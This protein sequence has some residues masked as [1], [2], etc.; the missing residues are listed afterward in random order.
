MRNV[1]SILPEWLEKPLKHFVKTVYYFGNARFCPICENSSRRLLQAGS[2]PRQDAQCP[3]CGSLERHRFLWLYL[4]QRTSFFDGQEKRVLHIAP[5]PCFESR[6]RKRLGKNYL[7]ADLLNP[8]AMVKM[9]V[10]DIQYPDQSFDVIYCS[11]VLEHVQDDRK[12]IREFHRVLKADGW[13]ILLVPV[14]VEKTAEDPTL[15]DPKKRLHTFGQ[16]DHLR[17]YG[18]DYVDRLREAGFDVKTTEV[19]DLVEKPDAIRMGLTDESGEV[20]C[21]TRRV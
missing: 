7:T 18:P 1:I 5:E 17:A 20:Y 21:C 9:D 12:A 4:T 2:V 11:H 10:T 6:F 13:A 8:H 19:T 14:T 15:T 16:E 3:Y